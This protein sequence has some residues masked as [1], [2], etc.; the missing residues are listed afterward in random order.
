MFHG[1][2]KRSGSG[3]NSLSFSVTSICIVQ[4]HMH[5]G[6]CVHTVCVY[7]GRHTL[8]YKNSTKSNAVTLTGLLNLHLVSKAGGDVWYKERSLIQTTDLNKE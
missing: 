8:L 4:A 3:A 5:K 2:K 1:G 6:R 7:Q